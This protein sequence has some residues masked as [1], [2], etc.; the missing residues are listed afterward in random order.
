MRRIRQSRWSRW[1]ACVVVMAFLAPTTFFPVPWM[2]TAFAQT[3]PPNRVGR[4]VVLDF[5]VKEDVHATRLTELA[6]GRH[7]ANALTLALSAIGRYEVVPRSDV[8][9][10]LRSISD[11]VLS[12]NKAT[13]LKLASWPTVRAQSVF[14]GRI[15]ELKVGDQPA[16][17]QVTLEVLERDV[18]TGEFVNAVRVT[19]ASLPKLGR[20]RGDKLILEA[21]HRAAYRAV[22]EMQARRPLQGHITQLPAADTVLIN[23]GAHQGVQIGQRFAVLRGTDDA[24][25][26]GVAEV[27]QLSRDSAVAHVAPVEGSGGLRLG[28]RVR[29]IYAGAPVGVP[30]TGSGTGGGRTDGGGGGGGIGQ[31]GGFVAGLL[32]LGLLVGGI[33][34]SQKGGASA[35]AVENVSAAAASVGNGNLVRWSQSGAFSSVDI[36]GYF[37]HR[38]NFP[39]FAPSVVNT[40]DFVPGP[41][42]QYLDAPGDYETEVDIT[43]DDDQTEMGRL[44]LDITVTPITGGTIPPSTGNLPPPGV[45]TEDMTVTAVHTGPAVGVQQFYAVTRIVRAPRDLP[46]SGTTGGGTGGGGGQTIPPGVIA[47][48]AGGVSGGATALAPV[49]LISPPAG[50]ADVAFQNVTFEWQPTI[51]ADEYQIQVSVDPSFPP[52][53]RFASQV[54]RDTRQ[55]VTLS[56]TFTNL[57]VPGAALNIAIYWRVGAR[58]SR[59]PVRP[60]GITTSNDDGFV[61]SLPQTFSLREQ[62]PQPPQRQRTLSADGLNADGGTPHVTPRKE[63]KNHDQLHRRE[64]RRDRKR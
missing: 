4:A 7:A 53:N 6:L 27:T 49:V 37:I 56:Q 8:E 54:I 41:Q 40:I 9:D 16:Q 32:L 12:P 19:D 50:S 63:R 35:A 57:I 38:S 43:V 48:R 3:A 60:Q 64:N 25:F 61:F 52:N 29:Q 2:R 5:E 13:Q 10:A 42:R 26:I 24:Q 15:V 18:L 20:V 30:P 59:D 28:D 22:N 51:G 33:G 62:P 11:N 1:L 17:A 36:V 45:K 58:N 39:G 31:A 47:S 34:R 14:T 55:G 23:I 44:Q 21:L 46:P